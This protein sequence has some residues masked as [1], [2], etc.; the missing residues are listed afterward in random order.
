V[1]TLP[2]PSLSDRITVSGRA[3]VLRF[4]GLLPGPPPHTSPHTQTTQLRLLVQTADRAQTLASHGYSVVPLS[5]TVALVSATRDKLLELLRDPS[6]LRIDALRRFRPLLDQSVPHLDIPA[7]REKHLLTG[8]GV[9]V[10]ILDT[11]VDFRHADLRDALGNT[12]IEF[13][14]DRSSQ[15]DGR[16]PEFPD[17][18][19]MQISTASDINEVLD[20]ER[21]GLQPPRPIRQ[22]DKNGHGTHVAGIV[23]SSGL[24]TAGKF[25]AGRYVGVA[26]EARLCVVKATADEETFDD[27]TL[28]LGTRFCLDRAA[29]RNVPIVFNLSLGAEG[30]SHDGSSLFEIALDELLQ[31]RTGVV[32]VA[33]AGNS[34]AFDRHASS[35]LLSGEHTITIHVEPTGAASQESGLL[36]ELY[37]DPLAPPQNSG[38]A[39][40]T[41]ELSSP[42]GKR[43]QVPMGQSKQADFADEGQATLDASDMA[44]TGLRGVLVSLSQKAGKGPVSKGD[45]KLTLRGRTRRYDLW[46][47][48]STDDVWV[49]LRG[50]L[51]SDHSIGIPASASQVISVGAFRTRLAWSR[52]D[53]KKVDF[54]RELYRTASFS[55]TGPLRNGRFAPDVLAPGEFIVS[56]LS[57][58]TVQSDPRSSFFALQ[59]PGFYIADDGLHG[60]LRGTSQAAPHVSGAVA[61]LLQNNPQ[62]TLFEVR[63][64]LRQTTSVSHDTGF[65]SRKGFGEL[66]LASALHTLS[67]GSVFEVHPILSSV[68]TSRDIAAPFVD[69][70]N[71]TVTPRDGLGHPIG[72]G[73]PVSMSATRGEWIDEVRQVGFGR[74]ERNLFASG[75]RGQQTTIEV[76]VGGVLLSHQPI[77]YFVGERSEI[78][79]PY[80]FGACSTVPPKTPAQTP[81]PVVCFSILLLHFLRR[82]RTK[83]ARPLRTVLPLLFLVPWTFSACSDASSACSSTDSLKDTPAKSADYFFAVR[84]PLFHPRIV[85]HLKTQHMDLFD[86]DAHVAQ[87]SISSGRKHHVTP[88]GDYVILEKLPVHVSSRYGDYVNS[89]G[90]VALSNINN[91]ETPPPK[92]ATFHGVNMPYFLRIEGGIGL[93]AG[94]LPGYRSS[95]GCIRLPPCFAKKLYEVVPP[96]TPVTVTD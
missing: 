3:E 31:N 12:R 26:P 56:A 16:H 74:Y 54:D 25:S 22:A 73:L 83:K 39:Q 95:H 35:S 94:P 65:G 63:E 69:T 6:V 66:D 50:H 67:S 71:V 55:S 36:L 1:S 2:L 91:E 53:G 84:E 43:L 96:G 45:F 28:L 38:E 7:L 32:A 88:R 11:G 41:F 78:G 72:P 68:G 61:L 57:S 79:Q 59:D 29:E 85:V 15:R 70:I 87:S 44:T 75:Q 27:E 34:G 52:A 42:K 81:I 86:Q 49:K 76:R 77:V 92:D 24:A 89:V 46:H 62:L 13:L 58:A 64:L 9:W 21:R 20:F 80:L 93:H 10:G 90:E 23:A 48:V 8:K 51:D 82:S 17:Y 14:L 4:W 33:A 40:L 47:V 5:H 18:G 37:Y 19:G 60:V 30:G